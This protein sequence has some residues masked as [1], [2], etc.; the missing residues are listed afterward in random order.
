[1]DTFS[2]AFWGRGLFGYRGHPWLALF[3]GAAPDLFS[4]GILILV[5]LTTL[6]FPTE[7]PP[8]ET[9][10]WWVFVNYDISHSFISAFTAIAI[11]SRFR[12][13]LAFAMLGWPFH[14]VLDFPFHT[15]EFFPSKIFWPLSDFTVDGISWGQPKVW[16]PNLAGLILLYSYRRGLWTMRKKDSF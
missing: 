7:A 5:R 12:K 4:F 13:D 3:F 8:I 15:K 10:P 16:L 14:I 9:I 6:Q 1:M 11:V 2:H